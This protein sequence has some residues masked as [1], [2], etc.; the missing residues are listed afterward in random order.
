MQ[1]RLS[2]SISSGPKFPLALLLLGYALFDFWF[3][4]IFDWLLQ[5][6]VDEDVVI[7]LI[8]AIVGCF[9][10]QLG[11]MAAWGV[12]GVGRPVTRWVSGLLAATVLL[13]FSYTG[14]AIVTSAPD[15][16]TLLVLLLFLPPAYLGVQVPIWALKLGW[17][18]RLAAAGAPDEPPRQFTLR[19][20]LITTAAVAATF[21]LLNVVM[22]SEEA[23][24]LIGVGLLGGSVWGVLAVVPCLL[25]A[26]VSKTPRKGAALLFA[27]IGVMSLGVPTIALMTSGIWGL[28]DEFIALATWTIWGAIVFTSI[29]GTLFG[30]FC[31][32]RHYGYALRRNGIETK[33]DA[34]ARHRPGPNR[35]E[36]LEP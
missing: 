23:V 2:Q 18:C 30:S 22:R 32:L 19:G 5:G 8:A 7:P 28:G 6:R 26:F 10:A 33:G 24:N 12:L 13:C 11:V 15:R 31:V 16:D 36:P 27:Y 29:G 21:G 14:A 20:L 4:A 34:G 25:S 3:L 35:V 17:G 9:L 1:T